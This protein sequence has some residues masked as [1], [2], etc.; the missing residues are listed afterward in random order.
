MGTVNSLEK[1]VENNVRKRFKQRSKIRTNNLK[2]LKRKNPK[3]I[4]AL[5][6][7]ERIERKKKLLGIKNDRVLEGLI[8]QNNL[9]PINYLELGRIVSESICKIEVKDTNGK[10]V[11]HG[12]GFLIS[13]SLLLTNNHILSSKDLCKRSIAQFNYEDDDNFNPRQVVNFKLDPDLFFYNNEK[14]DFALVAVKPNALDNSPLSKFRFVKLIE[15]TGKAVIGDFVTLIQHP[16][17][18]K[19]QIAIRENRVVDLPSDNYIHYMADSTGGSS[20]APVFND[21]WQ[22]VALH[23]AG[24]PKRDSKK[25]ELAIDGRVW[26]KYMGEDKKQYIANEGIRI[27]KIINDLKSKKDSFS[28][29]SKKILGEF[30]KTVIII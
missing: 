18:E 17:G 23:H 4:L 1:N 10:T 7:R 13:P 11:S 12:T 21:M 5:D 25:R 15:G 16:N 9:M 2:V 6:T 28:Q 22:V 30:L 24:V 29:K 19:K 20:G 26:E 8:A 3:E 14:L 27:S